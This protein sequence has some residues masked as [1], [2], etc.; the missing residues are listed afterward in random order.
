MRERKVKCNTVNTITGLSSTSHI[1]FPLI[2]FLLHYDWFSSLSSDRHQESSSAEAS[3]C[4]KERC[5]EVLAGR[6]SATT[7]FLEQN[8]VHSSGKLEQQQRQMT[9]PKC[10]SGEAEVS[11]NTERAV[12]DLCVSL[13]LEVAKSHLIFLD[14]SYDQKFGSKPNIQ[15]QVK[16]IILR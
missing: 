13:T 15:M 12:I 3:I 1:N 7:E 16:D 5:L 2:L 11:R 4:R 6:S 8:D 14:D 10:A 9:D